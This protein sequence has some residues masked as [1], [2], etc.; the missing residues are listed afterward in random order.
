M[1][2]HTHTHTHTYIH[3]DDRGLLLLSSHHEPKGSGE[4]KKTTYMDVWG[5]CLGPMTSVV[6]RK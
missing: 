5:D 1:F 4:L 6:I 2:V 3:M